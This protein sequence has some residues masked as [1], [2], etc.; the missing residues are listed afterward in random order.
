MNDA[1]QQRVEQ[2]V[3]EILSLVQWA[4]EESRGAALSRVTTMLAEPRKPADATR[5]ARGNP[6][7]GRA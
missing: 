6:E 5:S 4:R 2:F 7:R 1:I 3:Q